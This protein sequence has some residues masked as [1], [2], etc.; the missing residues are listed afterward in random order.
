MGMGA[1]ALA[2]ASTRRAVI[3]EGAADAILLPTILRQANGLDR[4]QYQVAP[5]LANVD[6]AAIREL[7][8][9]AARVAYV[10]D[11]D[12]A[13]DAKENLLIDTGVPKGRIL[14]LGSRRSEIVLE[15]LLDP[16]VYLEAVNDELGRW[17]AGVQMPKSAL[18]AA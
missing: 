6:A 15:D 2:F 12:A 14:R 13:G 7:D 5:G 16:D 3:G 4:L 17:S 11:G 18:P 1:S 9:V 10:L 8:L